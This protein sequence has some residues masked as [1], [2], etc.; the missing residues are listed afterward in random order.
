MQGCAR[1]QPPALLG[2]PAWL[3]RGDWDGA[4]ASVA[5]VNFCRRCARLKRTSLHLWRCPPRKAGRVILMPPC[6]PPRFA[7]SSAAAPK[8]PCHA[9][10]LPAHQYCPSP[11]P[12]GCLPTARYP[13]AHPFPTGR[14][15]ASHRVLP[16]ATPAE[17][18]HYADSEWDWLRGALSTVDRNYGWLLNTLHHHIA[19][20]QRLRNACRAL[21]SALLNLAA[22]LAANAQQR[23]RAALP[24][25]TFTSAA[26]TLRPAASALQDTHVAHHLFSTMPHYHAQEAT[27]ALK[28]ILG[29][30][31]RCR[32]GSTGGVAAPG[33]SSPN[34]HTW[35]P[36][37]V[38]GRVANAQALRGRA[39][40]AAAD[41]CSQ[42]GAGRPH[43]AR[44]SCPSRRYDNRPLLKAMWTDYTLCR[45]AP[46]LLPA[47]PPERLD[48]LPCLPASPR[49]TPC[50]GPFC[51]APL[52]PA[53]HSAL[54]C[55]MAVPSGPTLLPGKPASPALAPLHACPFQIRGA[56]HPG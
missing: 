19:V 36:R 49:A 52:A 20:G 12:L 15:P 54:R 45:C 4:A 31:Y 30:Y 53:P 51:A 7:P 43:P 2:L 38:R 22:G 5:V 48:E 34:T 10:R 3:S 37:A 1:R 8:S 44:D 46:A 17:L 13:A 14:H 55:S 28:P 25:T 24:A 56:R 21:L 18:P 50:P 6:V 32:A 39:C 35:Q 47:F 29:D 26:T 23:W 40:M 16:A 11:L 41:P 9:G 27:R 33:P 42:P